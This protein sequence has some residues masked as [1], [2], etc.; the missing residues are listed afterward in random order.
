MLI[1][2]DSK[3]NDMHDDE[4]NV[5]R[6]QIGVHDNRIIVEREGRS[7]TKVLSKTTILKKQAVVNYFVSLVFRYILFYVLRTLSTYCKICSCNQSQ[8]KLLRTSF[9]YVKIA[10]GWKMMMVQY[11]HVCLEDIVEET[12]NVILLLVGMTLSRPKD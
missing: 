8:Q 2:K 10:F 11:I 5:E 12:M 6:E 1:D 3:H 9:L 7:Q 4:Q